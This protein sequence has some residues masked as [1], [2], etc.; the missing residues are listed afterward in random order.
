MT[1]EQNPLGLKKIH[2]VE[3]YVGNAKQA[4]FYYRHAFG[5]SR[6]AYSGLET[7]NREV[8]SYVMRQNRVNFI[9]TTPLSED[10]FAAEHIRVHGDGVR[11]IAFQVEDCD[12]AFNEAVRRGAKVIA[13]PHDMK[14]E[15]GTVRHAAIATYGDTIHSLISYGGNPHVSKGANGNGN[16]N[17]ENRPAGETPSPLLR[18]EGSHDYSGVF[19]PGFEEQKVEGKDVGIVLIDHMVGNVE[20]GKM[21]YW[22]DFYRDTLGFY[23]YITFD[24]KDI[25]T[26]YSALMSIVM[27]DGGHNI[28]FPINEPAESKKGKSQIQEYI[29]YYR[30]AG[31]QHVALLCKDI[32]QTVAQLKENGVEFL[33]VPDTY[34]EEM[35]ERVGEIDEDI[36]EL[37]KLGLL[38]DKDEEGYLLQIFTKPVE[39]RPTLFFEILQRKGCKG[40]GKGNFK[41][42]FVSIEE[43]QRRRGN[44]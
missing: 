3:F 31:V 18:T 36:T 15:F 30:S 4:E 34:Y 22:C 39:D 19:L 9:L 13:E 24:D 32:V 17:P 16:G 23:R 27:S 42:L 21:N 26:E 28:K 40:F 6:L 37:K 7:G 10:H 29:D 44:L 33:T 5:F 8:T 25:S 41:A 12:Y 11:D 20:L 43:E 38:V 35:P 1:T 2:H 14:D